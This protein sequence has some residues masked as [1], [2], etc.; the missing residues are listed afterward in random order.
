MPFGL[1]NAPSTFQ[2]LMEGVLRGLTAWEM[3]PGLYDQTF[4]E[5]LANLQAVFERLNQA[6]LK[7]K[8]KN[9][10]LQRGKLSTSAM[11]C[12]PRGWP[13]IP[14]RWKQSKRSHFPRI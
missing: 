1:T 11:L 8:L 13:R 12:L 9:I 6:Q 5:H 14:A 3:L 4:K 2:R 7:L 10:T